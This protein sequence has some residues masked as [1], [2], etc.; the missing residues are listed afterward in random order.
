MDT[1]QCFGKLHGRQYAHFVQ[2]FA[3]NENIT[4]QQAHEL[5][6]KFISSC[7]KFRGFEILVVTHKD[8]KHIHTH[9]IMNSVSFID[10]HKLHMTKSELAE[11]K[12]QQNKICITHGFSAA[13]KK[14]FDMWGN[15]R[16]SVTASNSKTYRFLQRAARGEK[17]SYLIRCSKAIKESLKFSKTKDDFIQIM[18]AQG[19]ET[20]WK[21]SKKNITFTDR[22]LKKKGIKKCKVRLIKLAQYFPDLKGL[23]NKEDL[24]YGIETGLY[25]TKDNSISSKVR[26]NTG[27]IDFNAEYEQYSAKI[28]RE[29]V[30]R[31]V[32]EN[33][34]HN[35]DEYDKERR[36]IRKVQGTSQEATGRNGQTIQTNIRTTSEQNRD[37]SIGTT[38]STPKKRGR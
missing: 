21:D 9:F 23:K 15:R 27:I 8:R 4:A 2:S 24:L 1:K 28:D 33:A 10:G 18:N 11:L 32:K 38:K 31:A 7:K 17:D 14:G 19:F 12:E 29:R 30:E 13:P 34:R 36:R 3:P 5:A 20:E 37:A 26:G 22:N 25:R 6:T 16:T 35:R